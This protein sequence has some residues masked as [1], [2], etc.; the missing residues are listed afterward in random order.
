LEKGWLRSVQLI[1]SDVLGEFTTAS[2]HSSFKVSFFY[3]SDDGNN[4]G[5]A[6]F[7]GLQVADAAPASPTA[8]AQALGNF[9][10][11]LRSGIKRAAS[12]TNCNRM[13]SF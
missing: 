12:L 9:R 10:T 8:I 2:E 3:H 4:A 7:R 11:A 1:Y 5:L 6:I 13:L